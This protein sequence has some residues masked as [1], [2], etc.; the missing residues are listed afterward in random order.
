MSEL[1]SVLQSVDNS[2]KKKNKNVQVAVFKVLMYNNTNESSDDIYVNER[3]QQS[4][5]KIWEKLVISAFH[6]T[7]FFS[8][9]CCI[10]FEG[11]KSTFTFVENGGF[12]DPRG[13]SGSSPLS[14]FVHQVLSNS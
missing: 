8:Q 9:S 13:A 5:L 7:V 11:V 1:C 3:R 2:K 4:Y 10:L 14:R 6:F 12:Q